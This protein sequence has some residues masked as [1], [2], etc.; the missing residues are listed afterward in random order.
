MAITTRC[1][2]GFCAIAAEKT[3]RQARLIEFDRAYCDQILHRFEQVTGKKA[4]LAP[5]GES[6]EVIA[7]ARRLEE[8]VP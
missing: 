6:F 7:E 3:G 1:R 4:R 8:S 2:S 5:T